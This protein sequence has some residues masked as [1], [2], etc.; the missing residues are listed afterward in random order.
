[1]VVAGL[2]D[3]VN[4]CEVSLVEWRRCLDTVLMAE[5]TVAA[6]GCVLQVGELNGI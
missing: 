5:N 6:S 3:R 2:E 1:M 4:G